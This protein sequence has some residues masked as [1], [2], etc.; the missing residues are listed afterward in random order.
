MSWASSAGGRCWC[1]QWPPTCAWELRTGGPPSPAS[2]PGQGEPLELSTNIRFLVPGPS[3]PSPCWKRLMHRE[4]GLVASAA[5]DWGLEVVT[6]PMSIMIAAGGITAAL[7]GKWTLK[8][9]WLWRP[10]TLHA[11]L[12]S[13]DMRIWLRG[14]QKPINL[15]IWKPFMKKMHEMSEDF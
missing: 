6:Y 1:R 13:V 12:N 3:R 2:S 10:P 7:T 8:V 9:E 15:I 14:K 11:S 4:H 5:S